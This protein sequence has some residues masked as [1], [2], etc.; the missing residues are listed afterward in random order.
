MIDQRKQEILHILKRTYPNP[1]IALNYSNSW[2]LLVAVV[3][4][5][6]CTDK[7]VNQI[8]EKLFAKYKTLDDYV[9]VDIQEFEQ[10]IKSTGFFR[11]KAKNILP[12]AKIIKEKFKGRIPNKMEDLLTL[13]GIARKT[14]NIILGNAYNIVQGIAVD[15]HVHRINQRLRLVDLTNIGGKKKILF[16]KD[17]EKRVR[18]LSRLR[19]DPK[20]ELLDYIKDADPN[21]IEQTLMKVIPKED[22]FKFTYMV[23]DHG[24]SICKAKNPNCITCP[25]KKLCPASRT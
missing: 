18:P 13:P 10:D 4:S 1:K 21:K 7:M 6:Q 23:I 12:T 24:R 15:T 9:K 11:N 20:T 8:T 3:L 5:A 2:E 16:Q 19:S 22:W 17:T 14:A 25:L